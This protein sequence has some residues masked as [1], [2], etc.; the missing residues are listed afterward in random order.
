MTA[1]DY[2]A[3]A[4]EDIVLFCGECFMNAVF[5]GE[6]VCNECETDDSRNQMVNA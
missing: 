6:T 4:E 3:I 2:L 5:D 1:L